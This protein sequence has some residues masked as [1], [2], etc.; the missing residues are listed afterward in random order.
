LGLVKT[1]ISNLR[2]RENKDIRTERD[3]QAVWHLSTCTCFL[4]LF[5]Y[6]WLLRETHPVL[7]PW[8]NGSYSVNK[9]EKR[10]A[11]ERQNRLA[12]PSWAAL[13]RKLLNYRKKLHPMSENHERNRVC[14]ASHLVFCVPG[15]PCTSVVR[16]FHPCQEVCLLHVLIPGNQM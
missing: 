8:G 14:G 6:Q 4:L 12:S 5:L 15:W 2:I 9:F 7:L 16:A 10:R 3:L 13:K 11:Q 1:W